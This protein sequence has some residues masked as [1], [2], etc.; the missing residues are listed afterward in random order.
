MQPLLAASA[1]SLAILAASAQA[2]PPPP[3]CQGPEYRQFDF[4]IGHWDVYGPAGAKVGENL[5]EP[6]A[7][8]C[9]LIEN[10]TGG[11]GTTGKSLNMYDA[12]DKQ[13][14]QAWVDSSGSRL[15]LDGHF[16]DGKMV[17]G[18]NGPNPAKPGTTLRQQITWSQ[19]PDGSVRQLWQTS[20]DEGKTWSTAFDGK[21][22][23]RA[24]AA[25]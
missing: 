7:N 10:W 1:A 24:P 25:K 9:G 19:A 12:S 3:A 18:S 13:W 23:K 15:L 21:Y 2:A 20:V 14:H 11:G 17:L 8:G 5:I 22:V 4:W 6:F 16:A